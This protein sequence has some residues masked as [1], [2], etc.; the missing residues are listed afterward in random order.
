MICLTIFFLLSFFNLGYCFF[1]LF[2][3]LT[4]Q[5]NTLAD[6]RYYYPISEHKTDCRINNVGVGADAYYNAG[7]DVGSGGYF[8]EK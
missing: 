5:N 6:R 3:F 2:Q 8:G 1:G 7:A 4:L